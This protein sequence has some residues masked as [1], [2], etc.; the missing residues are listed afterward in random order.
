MEYF[1]LLLYLPAPYYNA[2][3]VLLYVKNYKNGQYYCQ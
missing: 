3:K 2:H 1:L